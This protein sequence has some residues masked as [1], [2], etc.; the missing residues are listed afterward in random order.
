[1]FAVGLPARFAVRQIYPR[2]QKCVLWKAHVM[3]CRYHSSKLL[4]VEKTARC[5]ASNVGPYG[6]FWQPALVRYSS[7]LYLCLVIGQIKMLACLCSRFG[8]QT[9]GQT[10]GHRHC[11]K[12]SCGGGSTSASRLYRHDRR[13]GN[14]AVWRTFI[15]GRT[16]S[17]NPSSVE[18]SSVCGAYT[19]M[20]VEPQLHVTGF[21]LTERFGYETKSCS[22]VGQTVETTGVSQ[23]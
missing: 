1:M 4:S 10:E 9:N 2:V 15:Q 8:R 16:V 6:L 22:D 13:D 20:R 5:A 19:W 14:A 18:C 7:I 17:H 11:V 12:P 21:F 23:A 3:A